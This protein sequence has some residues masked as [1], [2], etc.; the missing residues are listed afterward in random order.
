M[1]HIWFLE[2]VWNHGKLSEHTRR[3]KIFTSAL[4]RGF[5][6]NFCRI[7]CI[8][9][10]LN[11]TNTP[12]KSKFQEKG[13]EE[14]DKVKKNILKNLAGNRIA[15]KISTR[16]VP[17]KRGREANVRGSFWEGKKGAVWERK[18]ERVCSTTETRKFHVVTLSY[19]W[20]TCGEW[21][22]LFEFLI[23]EGLFSIVY[24]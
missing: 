12:Q 22:Q 3:L 18:K 11:N 7:E 13:K 5:S 9:D 15:V 16:N 10:N 21:N 6:P 2:D 4:M 24:L 1:I 17:I 20:N 8:W 14:T 23:V 19:I